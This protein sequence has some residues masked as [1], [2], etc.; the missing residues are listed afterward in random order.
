M[1]MRVFPAAQ[2]LGSNHACRK[3]VLEPFKQRWEPLSYRFMTQMLVP[4]SIVR[5]LILSDGD[6]SEYHP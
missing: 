3:S 1:Y 5:L 4:W 6:D 2:V